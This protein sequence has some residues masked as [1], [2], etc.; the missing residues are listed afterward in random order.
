MTG[1]TDATSHEAVKRFSRIKMY[2]NV[3]LTCAR[4]EDHSDFFSI[5]VLWSR[6]RESLWRNISLV[7]L[8]L[9]GRIYVN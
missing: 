8:R 7:T 6:S 9:P 5:I 1:I 2:D 4:A 3:T